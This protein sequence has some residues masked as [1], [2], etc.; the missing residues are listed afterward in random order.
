MIDMSSSNPKDT[1]NLG[2]RL[3]KNNLTLIDAPVSGGVV[4]AKTGE[5][6]DHGW[7]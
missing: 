4:K 5:L 1:I 2:K 7:W 3:N 6:N